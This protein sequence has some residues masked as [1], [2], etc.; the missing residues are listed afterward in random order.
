MGM[1]TARNRKTGHASL[2]KAEKE[3]ALEFAEFA[4]GWV[5]MFREWY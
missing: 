1:A 2:D 5:H 4:I 3:Q